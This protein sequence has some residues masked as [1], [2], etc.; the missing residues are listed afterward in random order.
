MQ[1]G[2]VWGY[3]SLVEG[4]VTR[5]K[6]DMGDAGTRAKVIATG[7]L[8]RMI[9]ENTDCVDVV[10]VNLTLDGL[11]MIYDLNPEVQA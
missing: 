6:H 4:M 1:S 8:A 2:V 11:R 7:G 3:I 9:A 10:D 5:I